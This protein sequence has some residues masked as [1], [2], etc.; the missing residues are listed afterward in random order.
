MGWSVD[1]LRAKGID[2]MTGKRTEKKSGPHD[3]NYNDL[4]KVGSGDEVN[5]NSSHIFIPYEVRSKKNSRPIV[6]MKGKNG[7]LLYDKNG[8][9][10]VKSI[11]S[12]AVEEYIRATKAYYVHQAKIFHKMCEGRGFPLRVEFVF[13][14]STKA[15]FDYNNIGQLVQDMRVTHGWI[16][17]DDADHIIPVYVPYR[18]DRSNPGVLIRVL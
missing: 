11:R 8:N 9:P 17:D 7:E 3:H 14:R 13:I 16:D 2:P 4:G 1:D 10:R 5:A 12:K 15:K 18:V 6:F